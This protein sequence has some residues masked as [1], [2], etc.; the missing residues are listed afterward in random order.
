MTNVRHGIGNIRSLSIPQNYLSLFKYSY[1]YVVI[2]P[3]GRP[4]FLG[5]ALGNDCNF[6]RGAWDTSRFVV[7]SVSTSNDVQGK[8]VKPIGCKT[9]TDSIHHLGCA[10]TVTL[11]NC[12]IEMPLGTASC[13]TCNPG[14]GLSL[15]TGYTYNCVACPT[16][17]KTCTIGGA[18]C[19]VCSP[20]YIRTKP[21]ANY[22]CTA[23]TAG[24]VYNP[25]LQS[26]YP[27]TTLSPSAFTLN[28]GTGAYEST[29]TISVPSTGSVFIEATID[30]PYSSSSKSA[31]SLTR[32][33]IHLPTPSSS[34]PS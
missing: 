7:G 15:V 8:Q 23:R 29:T 26:E 10:Y 22:I 14:Y 4:S 2:T 17:C 18:S 25:A 24:T 1:T 9:P 33:A 30:V 19:T 21:G 28:G 16:N 34:T 32:P 12:A 20:G 3:G 5:I 31:Q 6:G 13:Q 27:G 11:S